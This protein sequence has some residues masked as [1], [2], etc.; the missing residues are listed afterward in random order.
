MSYSGDCPS[1]WT[2][3]DP[4][5]PYMLAP[6]SGH[7]APQPQRCCRPWDEKYDEMTPRFHQLESVLL[8]RSPTGLGRN[9][10]R[11]RL[12]EW[13]LELWPCSL[14]WIRAC[15]SSLEDLIH[16]DSHLSAQ[17]PRGSAP[18]RP[19]ALLPCFLQVSPS[20]PDLRIQ[21][22]TSEPKRSNYHP[23]PG[24]VLSLQAPERPSWSIADIR[25]SSRN[26]MLS[27]FSRVQLCATL[28]LGF[29]RQ[30]HWSGLPFP[31]PMHKSEK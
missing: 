3:Q 10:T 30:E 19:G 5:A 4:S 22:A 18:P 1:S 23:L 15:R 27:H 17:T 26:A 24:Q 25:A 16:S 28:S 13:T 2:N 21:P 11:D 9:Q 7:I 29:S 8:N 31:S 6:C 20:C 14:L 12:L